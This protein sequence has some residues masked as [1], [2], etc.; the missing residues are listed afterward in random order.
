[1]TAF[2]G[3]RLVEAL[4]KEGINAAVIGKITERGKYVTIGGERKTLEPQEKDEIY[5]VKL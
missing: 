4:K 1:M 5:K 3:E 2:E